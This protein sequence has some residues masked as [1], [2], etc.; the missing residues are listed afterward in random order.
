M[1]NRE[2]ARSLRQ[3]LNKDKEALEL[4]KVKNTSKILETLQNLTINIDEI[5]ARLGKIEE[6]QAFNEE[7]KEI[8]K[9][10]QGR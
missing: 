2:Q 3:D 10:P 4:Q 1:N 5:K 6:K 7:A 8:K 9:S